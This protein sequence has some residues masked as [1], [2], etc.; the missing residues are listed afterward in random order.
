MN[1]EEAFMKAINEIISTIEGVQ[2]TM[3]TIVERQLALEERIAK[4]EKGE[5]NAKEEST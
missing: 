5:E 3:S 2:G 1:S 4:L